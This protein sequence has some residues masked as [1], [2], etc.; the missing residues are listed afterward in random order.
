[1]DIRPFEDR[2]LPCLVEI[3]LHTFRPFYENYVRP[4]LG[5]DVFR[6]QHGQWEQDYR[7]QVPALHDPATGRHVAVAEID[8]GVVGYVAWRPGE[9]PHSGQIDLLAVSPSQRRH[10][11]GRRLCLHAIS[12]MKADGVEVVGI[13]TGDDAFHAA[14]RALYED[15]GFIKIPIA[16]YLKRI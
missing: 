4:L 14:A 13:G 6:H 5:E 15:L 16:G 11:V 1:M 3:T 7:E 9:R 8:G 12:A 2:D 10:A